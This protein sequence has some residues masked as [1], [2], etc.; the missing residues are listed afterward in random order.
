MIPSRRDIDDLIEVVR[1]AGAE[2]IMPRFRDLADGEVATK[3][4]PR[5]LV[6]VADHAAEEAIRKGVEQVL[7]GAKV[8]GEEA[9]AD[10]PRLLDAIGSGG[11]CV[12]VDP[13][14]GTGNY[15][16]GLAVFG[17]I[18]AVV[19]EGQ[20]VFGLLH[21]P[22]LDDWMFAVR[23]GG[24]WFRRRN[25]TCSRVTTQNAGMVLERATGFVTLEDYDTA[26]RRIVRQRFDA[27]SHVRDIRCSCHEYRLLASGSVDFLR[28][29]SLKPWDHAAGLLLLEEAGGWAA[30]DGVHPYSPTICEGRIVAAGSEALGRDIADLAVALP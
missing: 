18:L 16:A 20:T 12:I 26:T 5:D 19:H 2:V 15:V 28:S 27:V 25:G 29:F 22:V 10:N 14:D 30:V 17:T 7:P 1:R 6:T 11:T 8:I 21:D 23:G 9:V 24:A 3:S 4:G 13:I